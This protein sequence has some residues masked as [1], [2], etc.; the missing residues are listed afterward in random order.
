M[1]EV[2]GSRDVVG[3]IGAKLSAGRLPRA[4]PVNVW[5]GYGTGRACDGC[6]VAIPR[7]EIEYEVDVP[8]DEI[9]RFHGECLEAWRRCV[10][11]T[12]G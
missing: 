4:V 8:G 7:L 5:A 9:V 11:S 2:R 10:Q 3:L 6:H 1:T 12:S